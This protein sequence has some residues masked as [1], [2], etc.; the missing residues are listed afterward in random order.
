MNKSCVCVWRYQINACATSTIILSTILSQQLLMMP[1]FPHIKT[2]YCYTMMP[3]EIK[4]WRLVFNLLLQYNNSSRWLQKVRRPY[5]CV[6]V[7]CLSV[8]VFL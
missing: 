5:Q 8:C 2:F 6:V 4:C 1:H 7:F 3:Q